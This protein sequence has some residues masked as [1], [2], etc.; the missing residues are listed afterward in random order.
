MVWRSIPAIRN[1][2]HRDPPSYSE[3][4]IHSS[5][6]YDQY[7]FNLY[8]LIH[9]FYSVV[10][11]WKYKERSVIQWHYTLTSFIVFL[12]LSAM[13]D[14][15]SIREAKEI[16]YP[17]PENSQ[18]DWNCVRWPTKYM[19]EITWT[20]TTHLTGLCWLSR[21][22]ITACNRKHTALHCL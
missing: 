22:R 16:K 2:P 17:D 8:L 14:S 7:S 20:R 1:P 18:T 5:T 3:L 4:L 12:V 15:T 19:V 9:M 21:R 6:C 11:K 13:V 10:W